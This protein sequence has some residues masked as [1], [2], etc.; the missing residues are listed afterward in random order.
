MLTFLAPTS[1]ALSH[2]K[3]IVQ[4]VK[5]H[6]HLSKGFFTLRKGEALN[7]AEFIEQKL[8][9]STTLTFYENLT[10]GK[11]KSPHCSHVKLS[12][13]KENIRHFRR[14]RENQFTITI[15]LYTAISRK[16]V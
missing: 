4:A 6:M 10:I 1:M 2:N 16:V 12:I 9:A 14:D 3:I 15:F 5:I 11:E 13:F 8:S 7:S